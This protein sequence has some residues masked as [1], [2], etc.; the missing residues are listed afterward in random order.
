MAELELDVEEATAENTEIGDTILGIFADEDDVEPEYYFA[1]VFDVDIENNT[2]DVSWEYDPAD[3][4]SEIDLVKIEIDKVYK[5]ID[6]KEHKPVRKM[7]V[8]TLDLL[9]K[10]K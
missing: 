3:P 8:K 7:P 1:R 10:F 6:I 5:V 2:F 9:E 4:N